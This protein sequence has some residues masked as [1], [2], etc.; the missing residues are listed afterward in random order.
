MP[1]LVLRGRPASPGV[2]AGAARL[3]CA[4]V[5]TGA[6]LPAADREAEAARAEAA[7]EDAGRELDAIAADLRAA[8][9]G[10]E[11]E[12]V[13]TGSLMAADP[14]LLAGARERVLAHGASA[15]AAV[16]AAT[17]EH[18]EALAALGDEMLAA[19]A[20]DVVSLGRRAARIASGERSERVAGVPCV[21]VAEDLGPADVAELDG[22]VV[23]IALAGGGVTAHAAIVARSLG[24][25]MAVNAGA[26]LLAVAD[27]EPLV[28]DGDVGEIFV[29]PSAARVAEAGA[30]R[31]RRER[32]RSLATAERD[33]ACVTSDGRELTVL[34]NA[35]GAAEARAGI[36]AGA[37]GIGLLRTELAF[38]DSRAWPTP[39]EHAGAL[40]PVLSE[41][42]AAT[43]RVLDFGADKTP[44]FLSGVRERGIAL[45]LAH[46]EALAAQLEAIRQ[47][48]EGV[49]LRV[50]LPMVSSA[51]EVE[52]VRAL[53]PGVQVGAMIETREA[54]AAV[55][56]IVAVSDFVSIG[57]NDL[58]H[59]ILG[60]DRFAPGEAVTHHPRVLAA[61][62]RVVE[63]AGVP[64]EVCGEA[65]SDPVTM[66]L[67]VGLGVDE[68]SVGASRVGAVRRW[69]RALDHGETVQVARAALGLGGA[70]EVAGLVGP[71]AR[72]LVLLEAGQAGA[73]GVEGRGSVAAVGGQA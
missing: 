53:L 47:A 20:D 30:A 22:D 50:M 45:L 26:E 27:G 13:E 41:V 49:A 5:E 66:P 10:E 15:A 14:A 37:T 69:V 73:E 19:R 58:T 65:A 46:P 36:E 6:V 29:S 72:R 32:A 48:A 33:L 18:A 61:I 71:L 64:V 25:P 12:I 1:E 28:V 42:S 34:V 7:L 3:L 23:A 9:R 68:L 16:V 62:A 21:L 35:A 59:S 70:A 2:G 17:A 38:L 63:A 54:V 11:A 39:S 67:L 24:L 55:A 31:R 4:V 8:G 40:R 56:D 52:A 57:T 43:V 60:S 51:A 44:P